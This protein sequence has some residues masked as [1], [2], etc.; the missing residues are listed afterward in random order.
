[1]PAATL[2]I[3]TSA[4][5]ARFLSSIAPADIVHF[6]GHAL[7]NER[8]PLF[9]ALM[10]APDPS[11][12]RSGLVTVSDLQ[13]ATIARAQ[14][15]VLGAC[16]AAAGGPRHSGSAFSLARPFLAAGVGEVVGT[17][18]AVRDREA[19]A[20]LVDLHAAYRRGSSAV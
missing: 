2:L 13:R 16:R 17:L 14:L 7:V 8:Y 10:L 19:D 5:A 4:T 11:G 3:G 15:V 12:A 9:S 20:I 6:A 1:Y 18:W